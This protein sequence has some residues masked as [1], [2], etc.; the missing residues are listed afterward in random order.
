[1]FTIPRL[2]FLSVSLVFIGDVV[3][4][5]TYSESD[6]SVDTCSAENGKRCG[7]QKPEI[8]DEGPSMIG[9]TAGLTRLDGVKVSKIYV[10]FRN[11]EVFTC[12]RRTHINSAAMFVHN[13]RLK[14][15]RSFGLTKL[16]RSLSFIGE[17]AG[18][19]KKT[20]ACGD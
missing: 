1:M 4:C 2:L 7:N 17:P 13:L 10:S 18:D 8:A 6:H 11:I 9:R 12:C 14:W 5:N 3:Y 19:D 16:I 15:R 20:R